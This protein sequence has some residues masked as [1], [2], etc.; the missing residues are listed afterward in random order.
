MC[1]NVSMSIWSFLKGLRWGCGRDVAELRKDVDR[2]E[3]AVGTIRQKVYR[4]GKAEDAAASADLD[5]ETKAALLESIGLADK[6]NQG[7]P[8]R[9]PNRYLDGGE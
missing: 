7:A 5:T 4:D 8:Q 6:G 1:Y 2:L 3:T 9:I